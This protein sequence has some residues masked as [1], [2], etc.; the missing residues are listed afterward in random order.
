MTNLPY[1]YDWKPRHETAYG[2]QVK[3]FGSWDP[4]LSIEP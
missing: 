3:W 2:F 4:D 1:H